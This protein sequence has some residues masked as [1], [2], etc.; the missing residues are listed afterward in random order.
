MTAADVLLR[1]ISILLLAVSIFWAFLS[2]YDRATFCL[3]ISFYFRF[4]ANE[5]I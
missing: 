1:V 2:Q 5:E 4:V 3:M